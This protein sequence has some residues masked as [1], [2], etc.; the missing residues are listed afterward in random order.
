MN[1]SLNEESPL[2]GA[3]ASSSSSEHCRLPRFIICWIVALVLTVSALTGLL[4]YRRHHPFYSGPYELIEIQEGHGLVDHYTFRD[5]PDSIGS[6]GFNT[7][8]NLT[9]AKQL[10]IFEVKSEKNHGKEY[11]YMSSA[12]NEGG[13]KRE[14]I[15]LEGKTR[16]NKG[17]FILDVHHMPAGCGVWP[18]FWLADERVWP[19]HGEIDILESINAQTVAKTAMHTG[20][21]CS[22]YSYVSLY[23][24]TG[25]WDNASQIPESISG[26]VNNVSIV[27]ADN[28]WVHAPHQWRN[29]GCVAVSSENGT[30][31]APMN[32]HNGGVYVLEWDPVRGYI[33]SWVFRRS[34]MPANLKAAIGSASQEAK[35][36]EDPVPDHWER[37]YA[38][39]AIGPNTGCSADHFRSMRLIFDLAFCG[40]VSG[41]KFAEDC[42]ALMEE[43]STRAKSDPIK[44]CNAYIASNPAAI[45]EAYW[46]VGGVYVYQ[47][48][49]FY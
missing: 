3:N 9:R 35:F 10:G 37:P 39:F 14:S 26:T 25:T 28:C 27:Q 7:Y 6:D 43:F 23:D 4:L 21:E 30:L 16:F 34:K 1:I 41:A 31:G 46:K 13:N 11:V 48:K 44:A 33:K 5:G 17:L 20:K 12:A 19:N 22:M 8:V 18:A 32:R 38:Y 2:L 29:Q 42:P 40:K 47:K 15:R 24:K 45:Q 49:S 36:R